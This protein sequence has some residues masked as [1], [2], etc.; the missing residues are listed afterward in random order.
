[1]DE[2]GCWGVRTAGFK[3]DRRD[4]GHSVHE[5]LLQL[6]CS[7]TILLPDA[8]ARPDNYHVKVWSMVSALFP[9]GRERIL[10]SREHVTY[11]TQ[12]GAKKPI[13]PDEHI[14]VFDNT[15]G[16]SAET[17]Y[18]WFL[19]YSPMWRFVARWLRFTPRVEG[20]AEAYMRRMFGLGEGEEIPLFIVLHIR[21]A[22][23]SKPCE[24]NHKN[25]ECAA[26]LSVFA[27]RIT[28][29]QRGLTSK[30]GADSPQA[31]VTKVVVTSDERD[32]KWWNEVEGR[33][34]LRVDYEKEG[35]VRTLGRWY[36]SIIDSVIQSKAIGVVG[37][38]GS[39]MSMMAE[40]RVADWN[41][42][43]VSE[44]AWYAGKG[45]RRRSVGEKDEDA[46]GLD[47]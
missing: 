40:R 12:F 41:G 3:G 15:Y 33:G 7:Y 29:V 28:Q 42:G 30:F 21:R 34:W 14:A 39:T 23:W 18:E 19:D 13:P 25:V 26:P 44:V 27:T 46:W 35:T 32:E 16:V 11:P 9:S 4:P 10:S 2:L 6:D 24:D 45:S 20:I 47:D 8:L 43:V 36:P 22:D 5:M 1:M 31:N 38:K 17:P 37:V